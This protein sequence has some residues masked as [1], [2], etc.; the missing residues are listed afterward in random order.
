MLR[1]LDNIINIKHTITPGDCNVK[2]KLRTDIKILADFKRCFICDMNV[3]ANTNI[4]TITISLL[5]SSTREVFEI[6]SK[7]QKTGFI[8]KLTPEQIKILQKLNKHTHPIND[9]TLKTH[10]LWWYGVADIPYDIINEIKRHFD[11]EVC[12]YNTGTT[13]IF[14]NDNV[15]EIEKILQRDEKPLEPEY[16]AC[17]AEQLYF[18]KDNLVYGKIIKRCGDQVWLETKDDIIKRHKNFYV[19][20]TRAEAEIIDKHKEL[21]ERKK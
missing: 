11:V 7:T 15:N 4:F 8:K 1:S 2:I 13:I 6:L 16:K 14:Q 21:M 5:P 20:I 10:R 17:F 12:R 3:D 18:H 9:K 19:K